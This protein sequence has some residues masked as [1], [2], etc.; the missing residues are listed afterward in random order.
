[1]DGVQLLPT[2]QWG[3][4]AGVHR[5][6][7]LTHAADLHGWLPAAVKPSPVSIMAA[8]HLAMTLG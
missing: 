2:A 6:A 4:A 8:V 3:A 5:Y 1:M 7:P